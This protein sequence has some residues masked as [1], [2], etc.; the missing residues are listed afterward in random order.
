MT[1]TPN[2]RKAAHEGGVQSF[3][4]ERMAVVAAG[5]R[6][7]GTQANPLPRRQ[8]HPSEAAHPDAACRE[9][10]ARSI[11]VPAADQQILTTNDIFSVTATSTLAG[12]APDDTYGVTTTTTVTAVKSDTEAPAKLGLDFCAK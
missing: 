8:R 4:L 10:S 12:S 7:C 1:T 2:T 6:P 5:K 3:R 11:A 9:Q